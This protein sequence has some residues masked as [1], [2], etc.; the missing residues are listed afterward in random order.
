[1][2]TSLLI[3]VQ[4]AEPRKISW[5][6]WTSAALI[7]I[8]G[9]SLLVLFFRRLKKTEKEPEEEWLISR[10]SIFV[11]SEE[12]PKPQPAG[13]SDIAEATLAHEPPPTREIESAVAESASSEATPAP[14]PPP[15]REIESAFTEGPPQEAEP[16]PAA[17]ETVVS[18]AAEIEQAP[19]VQTR[20][21]EVE[22]QTSAL[23]HAQQQQTGLTESSEL[24]E[25]PLFDDELLAELEAIE[26][27]PIPI[28]SPGSLQRTPPEN[29]DEGNLP[30]ATMALHSSSPELR[31]TRPLGGELSA[32]EVTERM[33]QRFSAGVGTSEAIGPRPSVS[34]SERVAP[35]GV[36]ATLGSLANYGKSGDATESGRGGTWVLVIVIVVLVGAL[37]SYFAIPSVKARVDGWVA[38][39]RGQD[40]AQT[41]LATQNPRAMIFPSR[42]PEIVKNSV[43]ARGA[44][45]NISDAPLDSLTVE[46]VML[47]RD[48][49]TGETRTVPVTPQT[50]APRER[51]IYEFEY[52]RTQ[53]IGYRIGRLL[54][55]GSE[56]K[57]ATPR[58]K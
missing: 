52:D 54:S 34:S 36:N 5:V 30:A 15:T 47:M 50:L 7:L 23:L 57:F 16:E 39:A 4:S 25:P 18:H 11:A 2:L 22:V 3:L 10:R 40:P 9:V 41:A 58:Q 37:G 13:T 38:R 56:V 6:V 49:S 20:V 32:A 35:S 51:G 43:M 8:A 12:P 42:T 21:E 28:E 31:R 1:M 19:E 46:L 24:E 45:D 17:L 27:A 44:V 26:K 29:V 33:P 48:G 53:F 55:N 14:E